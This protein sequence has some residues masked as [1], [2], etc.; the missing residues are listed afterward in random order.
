MSTTPNWIRPCTKSNWSAQLLILACKLI[1]IYG[2]AIQGA[3]SNQISVTANSNRKQKTEFRIYKKNKNLTQIENIF[4]LY[5]VPISDL[6]TRRP[7][8]LFDETLVGRQTQHRDTL[9][10]NLV[11]IFLF[12]FF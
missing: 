12:I 10:F 11:K 1:T 8:S 6:P 2:G 3:Q 4:G 9:I 5:T 7:I